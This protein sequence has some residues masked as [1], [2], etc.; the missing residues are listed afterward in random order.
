MYA[1]DIV[2]FST[3]K[4]GMEHCLEQL[5]DYC[6]KWKLEINDTKTKMMICTTSRNLIQEEFWMNE[7]L[8]ENVK[9]FKYLGI[10]VCCNGSYK[11][12]TKY[13]AD[14]GRKALFKLYKSFGK[15]TPNIKIASHCF[16]S[17]IK[18]ILLYGS[19]IWGSTM[20]YS[21]LFSKEPNKTK[22]YFQPNFEKIHLQ[23]CKHMLGTNRRSSNIGVIAELGRYPL[24]IEVLMNTLKY[25]IRLRNVDQDTL[26]YDSYNESKHL[27]E[28]KDNCWLRNIKEILNKVD[29]CNDIHMCDPDD[30]QMTQKDFVSHCESK[31]RDIFN[32]QIEFDLFHDKSD[33]EGNKLR[34]YRL[35]KTAVREEKYLKIITNRNIRQNICKLRI[36]SHNLPI[37]KGRYRHL[38]K[39]PAKL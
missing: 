29:I 2:L 33:G 7:H 31:L 5:N 4:K 14:K 12:A 15:Y 28:I 19:E 16:D 22:L 1:D 17:M 26:I 34:T 9:E 20:V 30:V 10:V 25:W 27:Y 38:Q 21:K 11:L 13:L 37:E 39:I 8:L 18:P 36:S 24:I 35:F 3:S 6:K 32:T 23:W